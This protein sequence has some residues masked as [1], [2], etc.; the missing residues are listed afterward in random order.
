MNNKD[1]AKIFQQLA[2]FMELYDENP[3]KIKSYQ[4]A[5]L[6]IR[7]LDASVATMQRADLEGIKGIG[8]AIADKI[9]EIAR[10]GTLTLLEDYKQRTPPGVVEML[11][12]QGLGPRKIQALWKELGIESVGELAYACNE[13]RLV[14]LSGFGEKTQ[15]DVLAKLSFYQDHQSTLLWQQG[16]DLANQVGQELRTLGVLTDYHITGELRRDIPAVT[17][18]SI[19]GVL[20]ENLPAEIPDALNMSQQDRWIYSTPSHQRIIVFPCDERYVGQT[21]WQTTGTKA[22][23]SA[24]RLDEHNLEGES[25]AALLRHY[26]WP[27]ILPAWRED[28]EKALLFS[29]LHDKIVKQDDIKGVIHAHSTW[30]DGMHDIEAMARAC[31]D[32]GYSYLV[33]TDHSKSAF[34]AN[35]LQ[36]ERVMEQHQE[37]DRLNG[38]LAPFK[39]F[40]GIESDILYN[41]N[42]DYE[43][44]L[45]STFDVIIASIHSQLRMTLEKAM[46]RLLRAIEHP[47]TKILGHPTGRLLLSRQGYPI[48]HER[49]IDACAR[50]DVVIELNANPRRLDIDYTWLQG[51][52]DRGVRIAINPDAHAIGMIDDIATGVRVARKGGLLKENCIN[53]LDLADFTR[54]SES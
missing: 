54:W 29:T 36:P 31:I 32:R 13:N 7:K 28:P 40:K 35:G 9:E 25:E 20:P 33:M 21:L 52:Q 50:H 41:G 18:V 39:I 42:L 48:D 46:D 1:I 27:N 15:A 19:V 34:Y 43:E 45:L 8:K 5:Y 3:F 10:S 37:I 24:F 2:Q 12:I 23:L 38:I 22:F 47:R 30:S 26:S 4:N 53:C 44:D 51:V 49:I 6:T 17:E 11:D 16:M 14:K